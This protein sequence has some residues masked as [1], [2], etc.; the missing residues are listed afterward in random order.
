MALTAIALALAIGLPVGAQTPPAPPAPAPKA[1]APK[2]APKGPQQP[3]PTGPA[4]AVNPP[5]A[6]EMPQLTYTPWTKLCRKGQE[7]D[8]KEVCATSREGFL[9]T[10]FLVI[11]AV[12]IEPQGIP[13][14]ILQVTM[15]LG[16]VLQVPLRVTI[17]QG[18][19]I[20]APFAVCSQ[21]GCLAEIEASGE[22]IGKMK[23]GQALLV[24]GLHAQRGQVGVSL[25][26]AEFAKA[27]EGQPTDP[28]VYEERMK[29]LGEQFLK[30]QQELQQQPQA[31]GH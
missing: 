22:L 1:P 11:G 21:N 8:A 19:P 30:K 12:L 3:A 5:G 24:Q 2:A 15:P 29:K 6:P 31:Q 16:M 14:K 25:P 10:G 27:N 9:D 7:A 23:K 13:N 20:S 18:Q 28:K 4:A 26:L 17:D